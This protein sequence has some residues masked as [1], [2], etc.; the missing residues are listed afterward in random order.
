MEIFGIGLPELVLIFIIIMLVM[1]PDDVQKTARLL[2]QWLRKVRTS[3]AWHAMTHLNRELRWQ[4]RR[5]E[6]EA[7]LDEMRLWERDIQ[8]RLSANVVRP[9]TDAEE[10]AAAEASQPVSPAEVDPPPPADDALLSPPSEAGQPLA[11]RSDD[12]SQG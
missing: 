12:E 5:L 7:G 9:Q 2:G 6:Q 8:R 4:W 1:G 11:T 10:A 3:S